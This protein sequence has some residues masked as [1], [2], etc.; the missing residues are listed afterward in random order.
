M[1]HLYDS[2]YVKPEDNKR[3]VQDS[4]PVKKATLDEARTRF[5]QTLDLKNVLNTKFNFYHNDK[6]NKD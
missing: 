1:K 5:E 4:N 3:V 6:I 2:E